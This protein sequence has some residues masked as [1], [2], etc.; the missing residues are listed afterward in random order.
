MQK[1]KYVYQYYHYVLINSNKAKGTLPL[2]SIKKANSIL[3]TTKNRLLTRWQQQNYSYM[4]TVY[5]KVV[6]GRGTEAASVKNKTK[7]TEKQ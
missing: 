2:L 1:S 5:V 3:T 6:S 4:Y 7:T